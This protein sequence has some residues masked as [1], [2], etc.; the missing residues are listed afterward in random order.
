MIYKTIVINETARLDLYILESTTE[1]PF[2]LV[3]PGGGYIFTS[4]R[5]GEAIALAFNGEGMSA[6]V[7]WYTTQDKVK[8]VYKSALHETAMAL[9]YVKANS[10]AWSLSKIGVCGFSAGGN[11]ALQ[12]ATH[13][14]DAWLAEYDITIDFVIASYP[15]IS[16]EIFT[17]LEPRAYAHVENPLSVNMRILG[18]ETPRANDYY[19]FDVLNFINED[20]APMFIWHTFED[21]LVKVDDAL[22]LATT[23]NRYRVPF[24]LH[25]FE[26]GAHGLA[27][28]NEVTAVSPEQINESA[29]KWFEMCIEWIRRQK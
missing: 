20:T 18:T 8:K 9:D 21:E 2:V 15:M 26:T 16:T 19:E 7:L 5:E 28:A 27:L 23:L 3:L 1:K 12:I 25:V 17:L 24:E 22:N 10:D 4:E 29:S 6:G 11:V 14:K 13:Y